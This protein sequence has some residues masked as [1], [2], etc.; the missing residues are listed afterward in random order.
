MSGIQSGITP[1][2]RGRQDEAV[3]VERRVTHRHEQAAREALSWPAT[4]REAEMVNQAF[5]PRC[6]A[7]EGAG[8]RRIRTLHENPQTA[9]GH[10]ATEPACDLDPNWFSLR[11]QVREQA[12][13]PALDT[14]RPLPTGRTGGGPAVGLA[15]ITSTSASRS[16]RSTISP[17]GAS[18]IPS[19]MTAIPF[20]Y[21]VHRHVQMQQV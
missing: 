12:L 20:R 6:S 16:I 15:T 21:A 14:V 19:V 9:I 8:N 18:V 4:Q 11:R 1:S 5:Q 7:S 13:V 10:E 17:Q 3:I 2:G